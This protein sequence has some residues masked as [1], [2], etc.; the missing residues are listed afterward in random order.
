MAAVALTAGLTT[1]CDA[2]NKALDC[3]QT[4]DAIADSVTDLQQAVENAANDPTQAD[5]AL[6]SIDKNLDKIGDKTDNADVNKAVDD[7]ERTAVGKTVPSRTAIKTTDVAGPDAPGPMTGPYVNATAGGARETGTHQGAWGDRRD[8]RCGGIGSGQRGG[9]SR[10][11]RTPPA[12]EPMT[13]LIL[14]TRNAGKLTEL[15]AI[16]ADA[17]LPHDLVGADAYPDIPDVKET[18]VTFAENALLKAHALAQATGLPG[19]RRRLGPLRR[20]PRR[21]PR[22][23]LRPLGRHATATTT[24]TS[25]SSSPSSATSPTNTAAPTSP[26]RP[27]SPCRTA[28]N[29]WS[30]ASCAASC[31]TRRRARTASATTRSSSRT[32]RRARARSSPPREERDQPPGE[33]VSGVGAG[34][35]GVVGLSSPRTRKGAPRSGERPCACGRRD[36]NPHGISPTGT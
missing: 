5:E 8:G 19:R 28:R 3:V 35:A 15:R 33:G 22:H 27:H 9:R 34:G 20:R 14:A 16:L 7:L 30:R 36:S 12:S 21:R 11:P 13:R 10:I 6:D 23:L 25:T 18:G 32:G 24:P 26:A 31:G 29:G 1:G 17:G 4:A 2:V